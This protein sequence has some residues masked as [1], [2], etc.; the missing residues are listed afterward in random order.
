[1]FWW[2]VL[3]ISWISK[4]ESE[5]K[6]IPVYCLNSIY[7]SQ[8]LKTNLAP[9]KYNQFHSFSILSLFKWN[10]KSTIVLIITIIIIIIIN[11][12]NM[13]RFSLKIIQVS[14]ARSRDVTGVGR[15][16][17]TCRRGLVVCG[18]RFH[19]STSR[20]EHFATLSQNFRI[21]KFV[22]QVFKINC[23]ALS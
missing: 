5:M 17:D 23:W 10:N 13:V 11:R 3:Y 6:L 2:F 18:N 9:C 12:P 8:R 15:C 4:L 22:E 14:L 7:C 1:M 20:L 21:E 19:V 16:N